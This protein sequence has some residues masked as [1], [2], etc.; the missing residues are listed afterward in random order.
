[1]LWALSATGSGATEEDSAAITLASFSLASSS[2]SNKVEAIGLS[3]SAASS[4]GVSFRAVIAGHADG[5]GWL[6][7]SGMDSSTPASAGSKPGAGSFSTS[8]IEA[9]GTETTEAGAQGACGTAGG[10][11]TAGGATFATAGSGEL[12]GGVAGAAAFAA[13]ASFL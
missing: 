2:A 6:V 11:G 13:A 3:G 8:N 5:A 9:G 7:G 4:G 1:V 10:L 12:V